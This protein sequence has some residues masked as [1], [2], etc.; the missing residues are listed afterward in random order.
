MDAST[1]EPQDSPDLVGNVAAAGTEE[2]IHAFLPAQPGTGQHTLGKAFAA[3]HSAFVFTQIFLAES[4]Q[5]G[6]EVGHALTWLSSA[7]EVLL[8]LF[9]ESFVSSGAV[10]LVQQPKHAGESSLANHF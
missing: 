10:G 9:Y 1:S 4:L 6:D 3:N 8:L 2:H 5:C 7:L